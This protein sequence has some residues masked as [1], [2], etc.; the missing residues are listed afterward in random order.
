MIPRSRSLAVSKTYGAGLLSTRLSR[1]ASRAYQKSG[2]WAQCNEVP[3][4]SST[5][6]NKGLDDPSGE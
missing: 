2:R 5:E 4:S 1:E 3:A 6:A